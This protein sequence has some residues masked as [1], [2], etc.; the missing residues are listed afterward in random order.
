MSEVPSLNPLSTED[1]AGHSK[2]SVEHL[3]GK[4]RVVIENITPQLEL[5]KQPIKRTLGERVYVGANVFCDGQDF[6]SAVI[7][8]RAANE[9]EWHE[10]YMHF[11]AEDYC[12]GFFEPTQEG[13]YY[14]S[15]KAWINRFSTWQASLK[16][17]YWAGHDVFVDLEI[18]RDYVLKSA[19]KAPTKD[20]ERMKILASIMIDSNNI[21]EAVSVSLGD[22]LS[23][24]MLKYP[25]TLNATVYHKEL[26]LLVERKRALFGSWYEIFPRST[27]SEK[28]KHGTF[29]DC[30][31]LLPQIAD[32]GFD[33]LYF[34][35]IHP[36]GKSN[37]KGKNN[38]LT[39]LE[40]DPGCPWAVGSELGG[41]KAIHP[42][43]GNLDDFKHLIA[44]AAEYKIEIALDLALQCS[45]DHPYIHDHPYWFKW[46]PNGTLQYAEN[47]PHTYEDIAFFNFE[48][49]DWQNL[50]N[51][52]KSIV[53]HWAE[54]GV[55]I[56]RV[57]NPH[58][59]PFVFW[60]WL[61]RETQSLYPDLIF[62]AEAFARPIIMSRLSK[63]GFTQSYTYF[64]WRNSKEELTHYMNDLINSSWREYFRPNLWL[65][66]PD[67]LS[68]YLQHGGE[69]AFV[70]RAA[71]GA[72]LAAT[73]GVYGPVFDQCFRASIHNSEEYLDSEK[74]EIVNWDWKKPSHVKEHLKKLNRIRREQPALQ[75]TNN[76]RFI[77]TD[78]PQIIAYL[79]TTPD[80]SNRILI[81]VN[82][83]P[84][85]T[86]W[87]HIFLPISEL[88]IAYGR[89]YR[90]LGLDAGNYYYWENE[91]NYVSLDP[92]RTPYHI[93]LVGA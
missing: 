13:V 17:K 42:E 30:E 20:A 72:T 59:K 12:N 66:T 14:Y 28:G 57:D 45:P 6:V 55:R 69:N 60:E 37:R 27:S 61:I 70:I 40:S 84:Y 90:L 24:L 5:G 56:F 32:M 87:G 80:N 62:L 1:V 77:H 7:L 51:E 34:P 38:S 35:P 93:L 89:P 88:G 92:Y 26:Q 50:W 85:N 64:A 58:T 36:I 65:N 83:D 33:V 29:K 49:E 9:L 82:L 91:R 79:K 4:N 2:K 44:K 86:Q 74:Y 71:L 54:A 23:T 10:A 63:I 19:K 8:Y 11:T 52:L 18:G 41:H 15:I 22:E 81:V 21:S 25:I 53:L 75:L 31:Q 73:Y 46:K 78:N 76:L 43:L 67:V 68:R 48:T 39:A 47:P 3:N 16:A